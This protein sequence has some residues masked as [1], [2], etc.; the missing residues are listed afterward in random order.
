MDLTELRVNNQVEN[1]IIVTTQYRSGVWGCMVTQSLFSS[2]HDWKF[3]KAD[4][5]KPISISKEV[6]I[7][8][9]FQTDSVKYWW[10]KDF[11]NLYLFLTD[12]NELLPELWR[13]DDDYSGIGLMAIKHYHQLQNLFYSAGGVILNFHEAQTGGFKDKKPPTARTSKR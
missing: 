13:N 5:I 1:G 4:D 2:G 8:N 11:P 7:S 3:L 9:G 10:H 6:L 12:M